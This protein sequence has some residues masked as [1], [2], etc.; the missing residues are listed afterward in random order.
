MQHKHDDGLDGVPHQRRV[1]LSAQ[2]EGDDQPYLDHRDGERKHQRP[3]GLAHP[4]RHHLGM[5]DGRNHV[6]EQHRGQHQRERLQTHL[7]DQEPRCHAERR[8]NSCVQG[9]SIDGCAGH[10]PS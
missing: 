7:A 1:G 6:A 5:V 2:H 4:E 9:N 8:Q 10:A 3:E